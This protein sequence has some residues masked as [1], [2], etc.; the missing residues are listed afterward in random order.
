M[1]KYILLIATLVALAGCERTTYKSNVP[2]YPVH[3]E[4]NT[5]VGMYVHFVP[6]NVMTYLI[7]DPHGI[8]LNGQ[9]QPL[10]VQDAYGYAGTVVYIDAFNTYSAYD[11][12]CPKCMS[13]HTPCTIDGLFAECPICHEQYDIYSGNG[14]PT[15]G[16][17]VEA[18][19]RYQTTY[20]PTSGVVLV[21][22][23]L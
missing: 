17:G 8:H 10:S 19:K 16:I 5:R 13:I 22:R 6:E 2:D 14:V 15:R 3:L 18:L 1:K 7:A 21:T 11:I 9:T 23:R 4:I 20:N 12:C